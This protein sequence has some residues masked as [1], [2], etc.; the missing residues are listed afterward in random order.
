MNFMDLIP[1]LKF[2]H[3]HSILKHTVNN[4]S[5]T[6]TLIIQVQIIYEEDTV[7]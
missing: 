4:F 3:S 2:L 1:V 6:K 7:V 5:S